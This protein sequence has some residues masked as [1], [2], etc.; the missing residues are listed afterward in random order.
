MLSQYLAI[1]GTTTNPAVHAPE[2]VHAML[3][4]HSGLQCIWCIIHLAVQ[5]VY[6]LVTDQR[7][8]SVARP[9]GAFAHAEPTCACNWWDA[10]CLPHGPS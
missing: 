3:L 2:F 1:L 8:S 5:T 7:Q 4:M 6:Q 10:I 9:P